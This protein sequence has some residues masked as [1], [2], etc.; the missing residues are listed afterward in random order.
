LGDD[1]L[2][3]SS[4][5]VSAKSVL[6]VGGYVG[7]YFAGSWCPPCRPFLPKLMQTYRACH[8]KG[9]Q[10]ELVFVSADE[11]N[12]AFAASFKPM[13]WYALPLGDPRID[14]IT[15]RCAVSELPSLVIGTFPRLAGELR[16]HSPRAHM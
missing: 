2:D 10:F 5:L 12:S 11:D 7:F 9:H 13:P 16:H 4:T 1:I 8:S 3:A 6:H 15:D 14:Q